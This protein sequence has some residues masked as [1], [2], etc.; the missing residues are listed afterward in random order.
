MPLTIDVQTLPSPILEFG[1]KGESTEPKQGLAESGPFS[2]RFGD[3]H[4]AQV[5]LGLVGPPGILERAYQWFVRC[6]GVIFSEQKNVGEYPDFPGFRQTFRSSLIV[7]PRWSI[8]I[9]EAELEKALKMLSKD[10]FDKVLD[11][12]AHGIE[13][14]ANADVRPDVTVCCLPDDVVRQCRTITNTMLSEGERKRLR[15]RSRDLLERGQ[16]PLFET[17]E[18]EESAEDLLYRDFRRALKA[19]AMQS[20]MPIQLATDN[21]LLD[22]R[23]N[24]DAATRAWNLCLG[25]FYKAGGIPWRLK[26]DGPE[27]CFVGLSFHH[28]KTTSRHLVY[29][30][31]AQAFPSDGDGFALRGESV[32]WSTQQGRTPHLTGEQAA[33]L[34][35]QVLSQYRER[36]GRNPARV[37]LH[38]TSKFD[39]NEEG[40]FSEG[41]QQIPVVEMVNLLRTGFRMVRQ[42][43]Y[44][45]QRGTL[46]HVNG[47]HSYL[48][49]TGYVPEWETYPGPHI[50]VPI[51]LNSTSRKADMY[52]IA[53]DVLGLARM[54]WNTARD[55]SGA[56]ITIRFARQVGGIMAEVDP[57]VLPQPSYRYYM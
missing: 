13:R 21:V 8:S 55:T 31:L 17:L 44:P 38:K 50:P 6:Q 15:G 52:R 25:L 24:Q 10:R 26:S 43:T 54:N 23:S 3:A 56:P 51:Q 20:R 9:E 32:P 39:A 48:F 16:L 35:E 11:L 40:G 12:Y 41:L 33:R 36:T 45:P 22:S 28:L 19:R 7:E 47:T 53:N 57:N 46:C 5:R 4:K 42:G 49:V 18:V 27:T 14:L 34:A 2:L 30:S 1:G 37:V 29:S